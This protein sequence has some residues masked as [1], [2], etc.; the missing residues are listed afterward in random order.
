MVSEPS[1]PAHPNIV[2]TIM[3]DSGTLLLP[4]LDSELLITDAFNIFII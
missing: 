1:H 3:K 4:E 2:K